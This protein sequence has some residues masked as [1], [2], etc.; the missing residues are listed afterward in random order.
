MRFIRE[1][2]EVIT[3]CTLSNFSLKK[4]SRLVE[5]VGDNGVEGYTSG[6]EFYIVYKDIIDG[7]SQA[8]RRKLRRDFQFEFLNE[9]ANS[10]WAVVFSDFDH[11]LLYLSKYGCDYVSSYSSEKRICPEFR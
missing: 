2:R 6:G 10:L 7:I 1:N 9:N 5:A 8:D 4:N 11:L 3:S